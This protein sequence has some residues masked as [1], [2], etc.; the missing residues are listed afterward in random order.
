MNNFGIYTETL[1]LKSLKIMMMQKKKE[2]NIINT[3]LGV[4]KTSD[5]S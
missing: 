4:I 2:T 1:F 3:I 5:I